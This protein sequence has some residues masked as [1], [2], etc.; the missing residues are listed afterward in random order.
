MNIFEL[1][2]TQNYFKILIL[3]KQLSEYLERF[4]YETSANGKDC[5]NEN[6][7]I[8]WSKNDFAQINL[9]SLS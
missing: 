8:G 4:V 5:E 3:N 6:C 9:I 7:L 2:D 1:Y